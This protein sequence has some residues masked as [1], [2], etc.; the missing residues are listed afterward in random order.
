MS[1]YDDAVAGF[2][3]I[4]PP[5]TDVRIKVTGK[6]ANTGTSID[7]TIGAQSGNLWVHGYP[8]GADVQVIIGPDINPHVADVRVLVGQN[9][10]KQAVA[11]APV[12]DQIATDQYGPGL[13]AITATPNMPT[14][15]L[16]EGRAEA[17]A[18]GGLYVH[19]N[20]FYYQDG[21]WPGGLGTPSSFDPTYYDF[22]VSADVPL[23]TGYSRWVRIYFD[24]VTA[25]F[26][27]VAGDVVF[28]GNNVWMLNEALVTD[29]SIP[30]GTYPTGAVALTYGQTTLEAGR[31]ASS[32]Y[33]LGK[34]ET[35]LSDIM[36]SSDGFGMVT[37][38]GFYMLRT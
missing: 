32:R 15:G 31:F 36:M 6:T 22:D 23:V 30:T 26:A 24:P 38:D 4:R 20:S 12:V 18:L 3:R 2:R 25:T 35:E 37:A 27:T 10:A 34:E 14:L 5:Y 33:F 13:I 11:F 9:M 7:P 17:S 16:I 28:T 19:V 29:I 8:R 1:D 21:Y